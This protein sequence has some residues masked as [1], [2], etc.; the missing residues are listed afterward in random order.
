MAGAGDHG[1][2][3]AGSVEGA[4]DWGIFGLGA[5]CS[6]LALWEH[7]GLELEKLGDC[8][9]LAAW[10]VGEAMECAELR[11]GPH[12]CHCS[13]GPCVF[14]GKAGPC[15]TISSQSESQRLC[16]GICRAG[17]ALKSGSWEAICSSF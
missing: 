3:G 12:H 1:V 16:T 7:W 13:L 9:K 14:S 15:F 11:F 8:L 6:D 17:W 10:D 5:P 4:G 2:L